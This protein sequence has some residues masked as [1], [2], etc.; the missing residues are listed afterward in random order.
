MG[1]QEHHEQV[2][3]SGSRNQLQ[4]IAKVIMH[5]SV[6]M[7]LEPIGVLGQECEPNPSSNSGE[8]GFSY[9]FYAVAF[10]LL[11]V[12]CLGVWLFSIRFRNL[13]KEIDSM[14]NQLG[15]HYDYAAWLC[16]RL[17]TV[18]WMM[19]E[20]NS[21]NYRLNRLDAHVTVF[22]EDIRESHNTL[23]DATDCIRYGLMELGGFVRETQLTSSQRTHMY[24]QE[25]ANF[26]CSL[27]AQAED[28]RHD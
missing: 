3:K 9:R 21:V 6:A 11:L 14:Q 15:D 1:E 10:T 27:E 16:E 22:D 19:D 20:G 12:V 24:T 2:E 25:R 28:G 18:G 17:D 4:K 5:L 8:T 23:D 13:L 7:G 26:K